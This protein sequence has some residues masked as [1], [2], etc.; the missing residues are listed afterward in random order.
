MSVTKTEYNPGLKDVCTESVDP[1]SQTKLF[2]PLEPIVEAIIVP[3][4]R[5]LQETLVEDNNN[6]ILQGHIIEISEV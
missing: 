4:A 3:L 5:P 1:L 6:E 2:P